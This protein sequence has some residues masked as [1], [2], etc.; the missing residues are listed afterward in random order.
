MKFVKEF[1]D[2]DI[3]PILQFLSGNTKPFEKSQLYSSAT[4][5]K[6]VDE[7][8]RQ[9]KF[10][11][12]EEEKLF[13]LLVPLVERLSNEDEE[14]TFAIRRNDVTHIVYEEGGF[15]QTHRDFLSVK[16]NL[17]EEYTLILC[18]TPPDKAQAGVQG[19]ETKICINPTTSHLCKGTTVP[20]SGVLFRKDLRHEGS[21]LEKGEKH[22]LTLNVW[23]TRKTSE[24]LLY[25]KFP[26]QAADPGVAE[27]GQEKAGKET[28]EAF[29]K[30]EDSYVFK[31]S[32]LALFPESF[33][34]AKIAFEEN[35]AAME[36]R[37]PPAVI[38]WTCDHATFEEFGTVARILR[39][40]YVSPEELEKR[41]DLIRFHGLDERF[42][43]V[44]V[45]LGDVEASTE[46]DGH[47]KGKTEGEELEQPQS[48]KESAENKNSL[49]PGAFLDQHMGRS[50]SD[51]DMDPDERGLVDKENDPL[52]IKA[53]EFWKEEEKR[54][55]EA[56]ESG[57]MHLI[58]CE[59][60]ER[61]QLVSATAKALGF[62]NYVPFR[63]VFCEG[64]KH[65]GGGLTGEPSVGIEM[66][67]LG[68]SMGDYENILGYRHLMTTTRQPQD[69]SILSGHLLEPLDGYNV[70]DDAK[71]EKVE[72]SLL[73]E[74]LDLDP[75][76]GTH[77][78]T[79]LLSCPGKR[80]IF[81]SNSYGSGEYDLERVEDGSIRLQY[82]E[83]DLAE[84][85]RP[86]TPGESA[87]ARF[88]RKWPH[89]YSPRLL[90]AN[91]LESKNS[92][93]LTSLFEQLSDRHSVLP[94]ESVIVLPG[95]DTFESSASSPSSEDA[96]S[97][98]HRDDKGKVCFTFEESKRMCERLEKTG[99]FGAVRR[100][101]PS[102]PFRLPQESVYTSH[103]FC[104][105]SVYLS[106]SV[107]EVTGV[108]DLSLVGHAD[109]SVTE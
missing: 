104:N 75:S 68:A 55:Q 33:L 98:S 26:K 21:L 70:L 78:A 96:P 57:Q 71:K 43:L 22:I 31:V 42:I 73:K 62:N 5:S 94:K 17:I 61:T 66:G 25:V 19:G 32:D 40:C 28:L 49:A 72:P 47:G 105:E 76:S 34:V 80:L 52:M 13:D 77:I 39:R 11:I 37:D 29:G 90:F 14:C 79:A 3:A 67:P 81:V 16:S 44:D 8:L 46:A 23:G 7:S 18:V 15:F 92:N 101:I 87:Q 48:E 84:Q 83:W 106:F 56:E 99:F 86:K 4:E 24:R 93:L 53:R 82:D 74:V 100:R 9:S 65:F 85:C 38:E 63:I 30:E 35:R 107:V 103:F 27:K 54:G 51:S 89:V 69:V 10:R 41:I 6:Y 108:V 58:V 109:A 45:A 64:W 59:S 60:Q 102:T 88:E 2:F 1:S 12:F 36:H 97:L 91:P 20:G 95:G 50:F